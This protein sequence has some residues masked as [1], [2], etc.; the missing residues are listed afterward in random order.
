MSREG[1]SSTVRLQEVCGP[2]RKNQVHGEVKDRRGGIAHGVGFSRR[3]GCGQAEEGF[4]KAQAHGDGFHHIFFFFFF[5]MFL[6]Q[7]YHFL[8]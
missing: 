4:K 1:G 6:F 7:S 2:R 8:F 3:E 5:F